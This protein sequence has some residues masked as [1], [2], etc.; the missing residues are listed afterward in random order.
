MLSILSNMALQLP[1]VRCV[2]L[3]PGTLKKL[4]KGMKLDMFT[5]TENF[6]Y[7]AVPAD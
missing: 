7:L 2:P 4:F 5:A 6:A 1:L 3:S